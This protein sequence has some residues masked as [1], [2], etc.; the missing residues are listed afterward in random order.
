MRSHGNIAAIKIVSDS[1]DPKLLTLTPGS[2]SLSTPV[3]IL[4]IWLHEGSLLVTFI[5][6][7]TERLENQNFSTEFRG[8]QYL[9]II[10]LVF[11]F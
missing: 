6:G 3:G 11:P 4:A 1:K 2:V 7:R 5:T 10:V 8:I 9:E